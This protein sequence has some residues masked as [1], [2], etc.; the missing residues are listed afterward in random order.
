MSKKLAAGLMLG[1]LFVAALHGIDDQKNRYFLTF[2]GGIY[3]P[4]AERFREVYRSLTDFGIAF[5][6]R[7]IPT[8]SV[9]VQAD[10][11]SGV[12]ELTVS[13]DPV[14]ITL[15]PATLGIKVLFPA[16][17]AIFYAGAGGC[18]AYY[19]EYSDAPGIKSHRSSQ[20]GYVVAAG[21]QYRLGRFN[22]LTGVEY[23]GLKIPAEYDENITIDAGG[24]S[25]ALGA[26]ISF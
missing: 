21:V 24:L 20:P 14:E 16:G 7:I 22:L 1:I 15:V 26:G 18:Y 12:G 19:R 2:K 6:I 25:L 9:W 10:Y 17:R 8:L 23:R 3:L 13:G 11:I 4:L 5:D